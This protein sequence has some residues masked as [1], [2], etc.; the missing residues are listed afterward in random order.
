[1]NRIE[2][3]WALGCFCLSILVSAD[4]DPFHYHEDFERRDPVHFW[5][6]NG[7]HEVNFKGV[8]DEEAHSG[9]KSFKLDVVL[10]GGSYHYWQ[11]PLSVPV[12]GKLKMKGWIKIVAPSKASVGLGPNYIFPPTHHSGC[13]AFESFKSTNGEWKP[14]EGDLVERGE[15]NAD[16]VLRKWVANATGKHVAV[17]LDRWGIFVYGGN[18]KR[19]VCYIDDVTIEGD[20]PEAKSHE[21]LAEERFESFRN[22]YQQRVKDWQAAIAD[23]RAKLSQF[24]AQ[25]KFDGGALRLLD[26]TTRS[27]K[28]AEAFVGQLSKTGYAHPNEADEMRQRVEVLEFALPNLKAILKTGKVKS[29]VT[30]AIQPITNKR[31]LPTSFPI[32]G[33]ISRKLQATACQGEYEPTSFAVYSF[34]KLGGLRVEVGELSGPAGTIPKNAVDVRVVKSWFQGKGNIGRNQVRVLKP[35]LLLKDDGLIRVDLE[36]KRNFMRHTDDAGR[37]TWVD[38]SRDLDEGATADDLKELRPRDTEELQPV[39]VEQDTARQFWLNI[40]VPEN[41]APGAYQ[42][43]V[44]LRSANAPEETLSLELRVLPFRLADSPLIYSIYYRSKLSSDGKPTISSEYKSD[45]QYLAEVMNMKAHGVLHPSN[46]QAFNEGL[47]KVLEMRKQAGLPQG[48][49]FSLGIGTGNSGSPASLRSLLARIRKWQKLIREFGYDTLYIYGLDEARGERLLSQRKAW[50]AAQEAGAKTFVAGYKKTF[51]A[52][53][54][55]LDCLVYA[56]YP[57]PEEAKKFHDV[58]SLIF[59]YANPQVG[60][61]ESETYRRNFGLVLWKAGFDGAMDYAY[62]HAFGHIWNDFDHHH[63]RDHVFVYP[64]INGVIDTLAWEGFREGVDDVRY[65]AT[66]LKAIKE[67]EATGKNPESVSKAREWVNNLDP[68][69]DLDKLRAEMV[70]FILGLRKD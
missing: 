36:K 27:V 43:K 40:H 17:F 56:G 55:L 35:E 28:E 20:V 48:P 63:Y 37:T 21:A 1:M 14:I 26:F 59:S 19:L 18:G 42:G 25:E 65:L 24:R 67:A 16:G 69:G 11:V 45:E 29:F 22:Q 64:T 23:A 70:G 46:Y 2:S 51:E 62:Q 4:A 60:V 9:K 66:L 6:G 61:E 47:R 32:P 41:A 33:L 8:S 58:G 53:G 50:K 12:A 44:R 34:E 39:D 54:G 68:T 15:S 10:K 52:M 57:S 31:V 3:T 49:F 5:V 30:M 7:K 13:G 38:I